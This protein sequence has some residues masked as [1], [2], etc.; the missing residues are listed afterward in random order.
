MKQAT[1]W[2]GVAAMAIGLAITPAL[3]QQYPAKPVRLM[4]PYAPGGGTDILARLFAQKLTESWGQSVLVENRPGADGVIGSEVIVNAPPDGHSL[5]L[6]V[7]AHL[8]NPFVKAK[9][10]FDVVK[11][12][13]PVTL[14]SASPWVVVVNPTGPWPARS[15]P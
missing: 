9:L 15:V 5:V 13:T 3:A 6:V 8:I 1:K 2:A 7:A 10:P 11:D 14:V 12:F 4:V